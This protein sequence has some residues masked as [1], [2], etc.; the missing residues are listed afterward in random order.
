MDEEPLVP[1]ERIDAG[2]LQITVTDRR[3][4]ADLPTVHEEA[5]RDGSSARPSSLHERVRFER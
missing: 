3:P 2:T 4:L 1:P 5:A